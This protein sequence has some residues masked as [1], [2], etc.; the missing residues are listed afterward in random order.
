MENGRVR[1]ADIADELGLSTATVSN[2][3]H[4]KTKKISDEM[5]RGEPEMKAEPEEFKSELLQTAVPVTLQCLFQNLC[6]SYLY[7]IGLG[8]VAEKVFDIFKKICYYNYRKRHF[9]NSG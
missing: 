4:G 2:V 3:I 7:K 5:D 1:I 9:R 6:D 8:L